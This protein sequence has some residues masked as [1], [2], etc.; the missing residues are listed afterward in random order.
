MTLFD[1]EFRQRCEYLDQTARRSWGSRFLGRRPDRRWAGGSEFVGHA[2][3]TCGDDFRYIDWPLCARHDEL[4]TRQY[5]GSE[6]RI[7]YLLVD[8]SPG[9]KLGT[10]A[11]FDVARRLAGTLGYIA[12]ANLDRVGVVA[13]ADGIVAELPP[14]RGRQRAFQIYRFLD[15]LRT[16]AAPV[17]LK[18]AAQAFVQQRPQRGTAVVISDLFDPAGFEPAIDLL[19][20]RGFPPYLLQVID[21]S[22]ADPRLSGGVTLVDVATGRSRRTCLEDIDLLNYRRVFQEFIASCRG[23][24]A[25]RSIGILQTTTGT[26][27]QESVLRVIRT[28]TSRMYAP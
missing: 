15:G 1:A 5:R 21:A 13:V 7:V 26:S 28:A 3:Y 27:V 14:V 24:C 19:A 25:R 8:C 17:R 10:P 23:Y 22:E 20:K 12:L 16:V 18:P 9:M 6:D 4:L 2:D 11:K